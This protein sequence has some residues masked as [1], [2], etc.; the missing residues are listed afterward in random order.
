MIPI[1]L[2]DY[3]TEQAGKQ[4]EHAANGW[5][6]QSQMVRFLAAVAATEICAG[7]TVLDFGCGTGALVDYLPF[8]CTYLG[9]D[10]NA[11]MIERA[12]QE[13]PQHDFQLTTTY[14]ESAFDHI[15]ALGVW[16]VKPWDY[17]KTR[18]AVEALWRMTKRSMVVSLLR[19]SEDERAVCYPPLQVASWAP[20]LTK[21]WMIDC[22]YL[23]HDILLLLER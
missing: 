7:D 9:M 1:A 2:Q 15:F 19:R 22:A 16:N 10:T 23:P 5:S 12:K 14:P 18:D 20:L 8:D 6:K 17:G 13:R 4:P 3:W 11:A 21:R